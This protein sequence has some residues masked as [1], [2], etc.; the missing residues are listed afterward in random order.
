MLDTH[1]A[2][3]SVGVMLELWDHD[4]NRVLCERSLGAGRLALHSDVGRLLHLMQL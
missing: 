2:P 4:K 3:H 1:N